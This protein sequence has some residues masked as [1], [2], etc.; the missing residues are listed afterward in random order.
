MNYS[1][2]KLMTKI[3]NAINV[4]TSE[5]KVS[6]SNKVYT[7]NPTAFLTQFESLV[8]LFYRAIPH[9]EPY[10]TEYR[11]A[12]SCVLNDVALC[13]NAELSLLHAAL[14][15]AEKPLMLTEPGLT[16]RLCHRLTLNYTLTA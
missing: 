1:K 5:T 14:N 15:I 3:Q 6:S 4:K 9:A 7:L 10:C 11:A 8:V 13:G 12:L 2:L 16:G